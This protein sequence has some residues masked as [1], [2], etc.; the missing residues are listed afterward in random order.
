MKEERTAV[1]G[2][3][4]QSRRI[5]RGRFVCYGR[6]VYGKRVWGEM[7]FCSPN[8]VELVIHRNEIHRN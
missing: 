3:V 7:T 2:S 5:P 6:F 8:S 4:K 1:R